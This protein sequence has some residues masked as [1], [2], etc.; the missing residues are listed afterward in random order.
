MLIVKIVCQDCKCEV[1]GEQLKEGTECPWCHSTNTLVVEDGK[2][3][4]GK[5]ILG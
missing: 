3:H 5:L 2:K 4:K 1:Q